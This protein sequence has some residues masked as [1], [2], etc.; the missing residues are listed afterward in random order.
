M[1][2]AFA[3]CAVLAVALLLQ[4]A[5]AG[6]ELELEVPGFVTSATPAPPGVEAPAAPEG[7]A[8]RSIGGRLRTYV[9]EFIPEGLAAGLAPSPPEADEIPEET[10]VSDDGEGCVDKIGIASN[11]TSPL[12]QCAY[13]RRKCY[14]YD[15]DDRY[16]AGK[17]HAAVPAW[18]C[19]RRQRATH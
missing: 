9:E 16:C 7:G 19:S 10:K 13:D 11:G 8:K 4:P 6:L 18:S 1:P 12:Y 14:G 3:S 5:T 17:V 15:G 2:R